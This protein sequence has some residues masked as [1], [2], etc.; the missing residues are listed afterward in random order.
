MAYEK[1]CGVK[2][3]SVL[4]SGRYHRLVNRYRISPQKYCA[5]GEYAAVSM[6]LWQFSVGV[7]S[8]GLATTRSMNATRV[9]RTADPE[10]TALIELLGRKIIKTAANAIPAELAELSRKWHQ[11]DA[12]AQQAA[13]Q[14]ASKV[15][16]K[17][18]GNRVNWTKRLPPT[19]VISGEEVTSWL[20]DLSWIHEDNIQ[21]EVEET[22]SG[23]ILKVWEI[24]EDVFNDTKVR[25]DPEDSLP[26]IFVS[27][28]STPNCLGTAMLL[29]GFAAQTGANYF[30]CSYLEHR[31][32]QANL[33]AIL[34]PH[35]DIQ[36]MNEIGIPTS[37][38]GVAEVKEEL[39]GVLDQWSKV[40][41]EDFHYALIIQLA[42]GN[43]MLVDPYQKTA[44]I[45]PAAYGMDEAST[46]LKIYSELYPGMTILCN[47]GGKLHET[48]QTVDDLRK[49]AHVRAANLIAPFNTLPVA[50]NTASDFRDAELWKHEISRQVFFP[51]YYDFSDLLIETDDA[52]WFEALLRKLP[53]CRDIGYDRSLLREIVDDVYRKFIEIAVAEKVESKAWKEQSS[54]FYDAILEDEGKKY[55]L[56]SFESILGEAHSGMMSI[57]GWVTDPII[58]SIWGGLEYPH[59]IVEVMNPA[60]GLAL[61]LLNQLRCW[62]VNDVS[63]NV[64]LCYGASQQYWHEAASTESVLTD[65]LLKVEELVRLLPHH[66]PLVQNKL[67]YFERMRQVKHGDLSE[68]EGH[69]CS[70]EGD[71][72][73]RGSGPRLQPQAG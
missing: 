8:L 61:A 34:D 66:Y 24:F 23:K 15:M 64:L 12:A 62:T 29:C 21:Y 38:E 9:T 7:N 58:E 10:I 33:C 25:Y 32:T 14:D 56:E 65:D 60:F 39:P 73:N 4:K 53:Q 43:W 44:A 70:H 48:L 45:M 3:D 18:Y 40:Q 67:D 54:D 71:R 22:S 69:R 57:V 52:L 1:G 68:E 49:Q 55:A 20:S 51:D 27:D 17:L 19:F 37:P 72:A 36:I 16:Q 46:I 2:I 11:L 30:L 47:D 50:Q 26:L 35:N 31:S 28:T 41:L 13:L 63:G 59:P 6:G 5:E 42:D